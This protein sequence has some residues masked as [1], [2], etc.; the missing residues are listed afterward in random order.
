MP[1][2][3]LKSIDIRY[4]LAEIDYGPDR[5]SIEK[6]AYMASYL[7]LDNTYQTEWKL[8]NQISPMYIEFRTAASNEDID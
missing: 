2:T 4:K 3:P 1:N 8:D 6:L 7:L 5:V